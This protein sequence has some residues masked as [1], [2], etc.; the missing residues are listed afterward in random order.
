MEA[1]LSLTSTNATVV[2]FGFLDSN[3][4]ASPVDGAYIQLANG[5]LYGVTCNNSTF[6]YTTTSNQIVTSSTSKD[7]IR[8]RVNSGATSVNFQWLTATAANVFTT[9]WTADITSNI[10]TT[11]DTSHGLVVY[12]T[13]GGSS[14]QLVVDALGIKYG[15]ANIR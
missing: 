6:S 14:D 7:R 13:T 12:N 3:T 4:S 8:I 2:R 10:P 11:R 15:R 1:L 5:W 9:N